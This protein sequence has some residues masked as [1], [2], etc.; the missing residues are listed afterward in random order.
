MG[1]GAN[2]DG[3]CSMCDAAHLRPWGNGCLAYKGALEKCKDLNIDPSEYKLYLDFNLVR[4][5]KDLP[6]P[7][8]STGVDVKDEG[9]E[10]LYK[11]QIKQ[12]TKINLQQ[13]AQIVDLLQ[14]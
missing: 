4:F 9:V 8:D 6:K 1:L 14:Q 13:K 5:A 7:S 2:E 11:E 10:E 12:L 3:Q